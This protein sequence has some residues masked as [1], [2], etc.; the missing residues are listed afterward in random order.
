MKLTHTTP[1]DQIQELANIHAPSDHDV[2][3]EE[4]SKLLRLLLAGGFEESDNVDTITLL[5]LTKEAICPL[6]K[7][8]DGF[9]I[10]PELPG[11]PGRDSGCFE[12]PVGVP[13][14]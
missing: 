11:E 2:T 6:E 1:I 8:A 5:L 12:M 10:R 14:G 3:W 9:Y 13:R 4:A 7:D